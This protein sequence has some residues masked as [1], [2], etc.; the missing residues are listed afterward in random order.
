MS[1]NLLSRNTG[2]YGDSFTQTNPT[3]K[4]KLL[5]IIIVLGV[6]VSV[7]ILATLRNRPDKYTQSATEA[8]RKETPNAEVKD[9]RVAGGF[10]VATVSDP[11]AKSQIRSGNMTIFRVNEDG[12]MTQIASGNAFTPLD[13]LGLGIPLATQAELMGK[14][15]DQ[16]VQNLAGS[17]GHNGGDAPGYSGFEGSF[18]P[19][20]WQIDS[21]TLSNLLQVL[22]ATISNK[23][24]NVEPN[25]KIV[26]ITAEKNNSKATTNMKTYISTFTIELRFI[27]GSGE[28]SNHTLTFAIGPNYYQNY[29]L[30]GQKLTYTSD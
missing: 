30:D 18:D 10:A 12:S 14:S 26:C 6:L 21:G 8:A 9:V 19:D 22:T 16:T 2:E 11:T 29:T 4:K 25:E 15:L 23:N 13:L 5:I 17:C 1:W 3:K 27:K 20:N 24:A 28:I 7:P